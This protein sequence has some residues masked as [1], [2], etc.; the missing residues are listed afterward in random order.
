MTTRL[1][2]IV[3][4]LV[5]ELCLICINK[6]IFAGC[7]CLIVFVVLLP[8]ILNFEKFLQCWS[9]L[10]CQHDRF[11]IQLNRGKAL[12][13]STCNLIPEG[14]KIFPLLEPYPLARAI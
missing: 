14:K 3:R 2:A 4:W 6:D 11:I 9:K 7:F 1:N 12:T 10:R 5:F 8:A 13:L